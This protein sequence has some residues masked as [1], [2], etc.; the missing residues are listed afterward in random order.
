MS[1]VG[2]GVNDPGTVAKIE[3]FYKRQSAEAG[4]LIFDRMKEVV[5][6]AQL[7]GLDPLNCIITVDFPCAEV[8]CMTL[9][10][11]VDYFKLEADSIAILQRNLKPQSQLSTAI[12]QLP[13]H[14]LVENEDSRLVIKSVS[15]S[16]IGAASL[17]LSGVKT[18]LD[19]YMTALKMDTATAIELIASQGLTGLMTAYQNHTNA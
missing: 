7:K 4:N 9:A 19:E 13:C 1:A 5:V 17:M 12:C 14:A 8:S 11:A 6:I 3:K 2:E 10:E 15:K 18:M 16:N